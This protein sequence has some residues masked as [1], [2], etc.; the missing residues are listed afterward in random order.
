MTEIAR[1]NRIIFIVSSLVCINLLSFINEEKLK[2]EK[3]SSDT[4]ISIERIGRGGD[5]L[6]PGPHNMPKSRIRRQNGIGGE[7]FNTRG[8]YIRPWSTS[9]SS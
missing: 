1:N 2:T 3:N 8:P 5:L 7:G 4:V 6:G 9:N